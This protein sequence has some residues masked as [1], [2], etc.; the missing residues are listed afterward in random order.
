MQHLD[1]SVSTKPQ[2]T[3]CPDEA[4]RIKM[5][6]EMFEKIKGTDLLLEEIQPDPK[7]Y[8]YDSAPLRKSHAYKT[9][10]ATMLS[11]RSQDETT[12]K[13]VQNLWKHY[14]T[15]E[16]LAYAPIEHIE[17]LIHSSGTYRQKAKRIK[18]AARIVH[19]QYDD[20]VPP[21]REALIEIP[22]VGRKVANCV[23]V[24]SFN[25]PAIPV[26]THVHR[27]SNRIGWVTTKT[28]DK[29]EVALEKLFPKSE[30]MVINYTMV[31]YGKKI[32]KSIN[33]QCSLCPVADRCLKRIQ[34]PGTSK[35][36]SKSRKKKS[37]TKK[38]VNK[39]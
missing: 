20:N 19:E 37:A 10:I 26:D 4:C 3:P 8:A 28:P 15:P 6:H 22:G 31:S 11:V 33:P 18:E 36:R 39:S 29:T 21:S 25:I 23:L 32:C 27:I 34:K 14:S 7:N 35:I 13:V 12:F 1:R 5:L 9:L 16:A 17:E 38:S 24:V 30:W 2:G